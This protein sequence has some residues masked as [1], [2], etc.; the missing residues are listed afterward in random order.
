M[1]EVSW[2]LGAESWELATLPAR[3]ALQLGG[4]EADI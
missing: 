2:E 3:R 4:P 1:S